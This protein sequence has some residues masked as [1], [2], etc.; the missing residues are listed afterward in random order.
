MTTNGRGR[1]ALPSFD[2]SVFK[3]PEPIT[4][5]GAGGI[6]GKAS[7]LVLIRDLI[8]NDLGKSRFAGI[9]VYVPKMVVLATGLFDAFMERN[10]L[11]DVAYSDMPD[12]RIARAFMQAEFPTEAVGDLRALVQGLN[13]PLAVRSSSL[14]EDAML[15][16]FAG[17]YE[18]KMVPNNQPDE[19]SRFLRLVEA[20][21]FVYASTYYRAAKSYIRAAEKRSADEKMAVIIQEVV[22][23]RRGE[24]FYPD[25]SGVGRSYNFF[26]GTGSTPSDGVV[27]LA[28][29]LGKTIVDGGVSWMYSPARPKAP[30]PYGSVSEMLRSTQ[31]D[32][33]AVNMGKPPA[34]DPIAETE[35]LL[36]GDLAAA[37]YDDVLKRIASTYDPGRDRLV[38]GTGADGPR[39]LDFAPLLA[40]SDL[41]FNDLVRELLAIG[42]RAVGEAVEIEFAAIFPGKGL[43]GA[44]FGFLQLRPMLVAEQAIELSDDEMT[45]PDVV[46]ASDRAMGNGEIKGV[47][48][49]VYVKPKSFKAKHTR[50]IA[51][52]LESINRLLLDEHRPYMLVGF[53]RWGS[54]DPWLG[55]PV[56]WGQIAGAK[57]IVES[58]AQGMDVEPSQGA[59]FFQNL[60]GFGVCYLCVRHDWQVSE[61]RRGVD[62]EWLDRQPVVA[63]SEFV[64]HV[65]T[66]LEIRVK[67]DGRSGRGAMWA[68]VEV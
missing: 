21:K 52:E 51:A 32:F 5:I 45:A 30:P 16:P 35:Y 44:R 14:L 42:K 67:V 62:W 38:P 66:P 47:Q 68:P 34:Y 41:P 64:R 65:R 24:R 3:S 55:I 39:V 57:V 13:T 60:V 50:E 63:E 10:S 20:I 27:N 28:L 12:E 53:G 29:G 7:G 4:R 6:G 22:G 61:R 15:R 48:D 46:L 58:T 40:Y 25:L 11:H 9:E 17:V 2:R 33:W 37:D 31:L 36:K 26:P 18:T 43:E 23:A 49:I 59:H 19:D 8:E 1:T 54:S 56:N